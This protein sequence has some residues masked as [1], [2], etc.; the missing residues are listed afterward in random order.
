MWEYLAFKIVGTP[1]SY[2]PRA[3]GYLFARVTAYIVYLLLPTLR[4]AIANNMRHVLGSEVDG[5]TIRKAT[6][7]VLRNATNNT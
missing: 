5:T 1:L 7:G 2:L 3:V 4:G 6:K